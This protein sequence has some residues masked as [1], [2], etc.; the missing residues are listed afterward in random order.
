MTQVSHFAKEDIGGEI[1]P[2]LTTGL[3]RDTLDALREYIQNS[4]DAEANS[5]SAAIDPST[6]VI[7]DNGTGMNANQ[8]R[9]AIRLGISDKNPIENVGFRGIGIYSAFNLC[10]LLEIFTK[11]KGSRAG[12]HIVFRFG[13]IRKQLLAEQER[14]KRGQ[15]PKLFLEKLLE[16]NVFVQDD[17]E[18]AIEDHGTRVILGDLL[19][20]TYRP[21]QD[22]DTVV[23]YLQDVVPLPFDPSFQH[24][25]AIAKKFEEEDYRVVPLE[26]QIGP[27]REALYRPYRDEQFRGDGKYPPKYFP[28][29]KG[30]ERFGFAWVCINGR[31]VF[32]KEHQKVRG[33]LI[34]KF[35]FSIGSRSYL[36]QFFKRTVFNRRIT[37]EVII[38]NDALLP[39][40]ARSDFENNFA[41]QEFLEL[42]PQFVD[43][44]SKWANGIQEKEKAR[45]VLDEVQEELNVLAESLPRI[46]RDKE[47]VL[48]ANIALAAFERHLK[49]HS[50]TL[51]QLDDVQEQLSAARELLRTSHAFVKNALKTSSA[52]RKQLEEDVIKVVQAEANS[53]K[54][55][56]A[57]I[58]DRPRDLVA[59][60]E[61][62]GIVLTDDAQKAIKLF[63]SDYL[64]EQIDRGTYRDLLTQF[65]ETLE[66]GL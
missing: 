62:N 38:Q 1:L 47:E 55:A 41:R 59:A 17:E 18:H 6:I 34:K 61:V 30:S 12:S 57:R 24:G 51:Q 23:N 52:A 42:I 65:I 36:E 49:T 33:L 53:K 58:E 46:Q 5:V 63:E 8:A 43:T 40:A 44:L 50:K 2:I 14:R 60:L 32:K 31:R 26:L 22:W 19:P 48:K 25:K 13:E 11:Q 3:Y 64:L 28:L 20:D 29:H 15:P 66:Q 4:I 27:R 35:G 54:A 37:G 10:N 9:K 16:S 21:L 39:N 7:S 45:E 56:K